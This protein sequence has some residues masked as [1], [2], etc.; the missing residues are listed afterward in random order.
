[1]KRA[2]VQNLY[3][4]RTRAYLA[5]ISVFRYPQALR[6]VLA[7]SGALSSGQHILDAGCG[8]GVSTFTLLEALESR[9]FDYRSIDAFDLTPHMLERFRNRLDRAG[10][11]R[12]ELGQ[13]DVLHL[14][15]QLPP[16]WTDY[17]LELCAS[18]LEYVPRP[19]LA[20]SLATLRTRLAPDGRLILVITQKTM[21]LT[22]WVWRCEGYNR[23]ELDQALAAAGFTN[24]VH[25]QFPSPYAWLNAGVRVVEA[26]R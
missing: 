5:F 18:M 11:P 26:G 4:R 16:S 24:I 21:Y 15:D 6:A 17:D 23:P 12:V 25:R 14:D 22:R 10:I 7:S 19:L 3:T 9:G 20:A 2:D 1:M 8:T 13:A